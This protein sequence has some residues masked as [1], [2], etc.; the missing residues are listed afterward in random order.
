MKTL[1]GANWVKS[2]AFSPDG[3]TLI[4]GSQDETI[5]LWDVSTGNCL[6]IL[7]RRSPS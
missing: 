5:K 3:Q 4:S 1:Q 2:V 6:R 7:R